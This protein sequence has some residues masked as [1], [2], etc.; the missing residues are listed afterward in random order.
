MEVQGSTN[1]AA[2]R[3][4]HQAV[5]ILAGLGRGPERQRNRSLARFCYPWKPLSEVMHWL[6]CGRT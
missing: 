5:S 4:D 1:S 2:A 6:E 3:R